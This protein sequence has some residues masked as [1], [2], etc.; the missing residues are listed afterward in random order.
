VLAFLTKQK[1][2]HVLLLVSKCNL[3]DRD[4]KPVR[5]PTSHTHHI[6]PQ[7]IH[8]LRLTQYTTHILIHVTNK[9]YK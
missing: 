1:T 2:D 3:Y 7:H 4:A 8:T 9:N 6:Q 5:F